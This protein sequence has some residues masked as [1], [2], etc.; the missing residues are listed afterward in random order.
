MKSLRTTSIFIVLILVAVL[1]G[2]AAID[3]FSPAF[4]FSEYEGIGE[5]PEIYPDYSQT[6][7]PA[8]IAPLNF[9]IKNAGEDYFV[10]I[11]SANGE[12]IEIK[13]NTGEIIIPQKKWR[14]MLRLNSGNSLCF[15]VFVKN[16]DNKWKKFDT[17]KNTIARQEIDSFLCYRKIH[18]GHALWSDIGIY[19]R[20]ISNFKEKPIIENSSFRLGCMNCHTFCNNNPEIM[21]L[22][23]RSSIYG[24]D[25]ILVNGDNAQKIGAKFTYSAWHPGGKILTF[26]SN[27]ITQTDRLNGFF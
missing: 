23:V 14:Q 2:K 1:T 13:S 3:K 20:D 12:P 5:Y 6:V 22:K 16:A 4:S 27:N 18:P 19:Q 11:Y 10:K 17:I 25:T 24:T 21:A 15:D 7:I 9:L 26:S 8:N